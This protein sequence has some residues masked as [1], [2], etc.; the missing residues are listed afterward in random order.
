MRAFIERLKTVLLWAAFVSLLGWM[1]VAGYAWAKFDN[2]RTLVAY[3][4]VSTSTVQMEMQGKTIDQL[5]D[6]VIAKLA[7]DENN[8]P[9]RVPVKWDDNKKGTL[10][11]KD[12]WSYG[13]MQYKNSTVQRHYKAI[14]GEDLSNLEAVLL[15]LDCAKAKELAREAIFGNLNA[16]GE[17]TM[18]TPE[19]LM[20][21]K[22]IREMSK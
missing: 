5:K 10:P 3:A 15:A 7:N 1:V 13:C 11:A 20:R 21:V 8:D 14:H 2:S 12:K 16:A 4:D 9:D 18:A 19:V 6:E 22:I 17:W